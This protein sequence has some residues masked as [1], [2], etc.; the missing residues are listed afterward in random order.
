[1]RV[2]DVIVPLWKVTRTRGR[3][4]WPAANPKCRA[5]SERATHPTPFAAE[6]RKR[7]GC[8]Q[9]NEGLGCS[10]PFARLGGNVDELNY[11]Y[12]CDSS[13]F[14]RAWRS[15]TRLRASSLPGSSVA[16]W[17]AASRAFRSQP[18]TGASSSR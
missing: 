17:M 10:S 4:P 9:E 15:L 11:C 13:F 8:F 16:A 18:I 12:C 6:C 5:F 7:G 14:T 2:W 3:S 1:M